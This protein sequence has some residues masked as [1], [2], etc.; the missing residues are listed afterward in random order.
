MRPDQATGLGIPGSTAMMLAVQDS[1]ARKKA[2][3]EIVNSAAPVAAGSVAFASM[4]MAQH[5]VH[6]G[7]P[8]G[9]EA[10]VSSGVAW[11]SCIA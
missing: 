6:T 9:V 10:G 7:S 5:V 3:E 2:A 8:V 1:A 11:W 4:H